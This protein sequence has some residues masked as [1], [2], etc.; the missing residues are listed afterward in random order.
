MKF[1]RKKTSGKRQISDRE[2]HRWCFVAEYGR[3]ILWVI[4]LSQVS[5]LHTKGA[6]VAYLG[7]RYKKSR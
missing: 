6:N 7:R 5:I 1:S 3:L 2:S 4:E